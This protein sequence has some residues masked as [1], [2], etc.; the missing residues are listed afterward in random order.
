MN[1]SKILQT[2]MYLPKNIVSNADLEKMIETSDDWIESRTG[3]K[4]RHI[5]SANENS[6]TMAIAAAKS[7]LA[8]H[9]PSSID[10]LIVA[11][12]TP[13]KLMPSTACAV[14]NEL[15]L[16]KA[17]CFDLNAACSGF[18]YAITCADQYIKSGMCKKVLVIGSDA[19]TKIIDWED[20][21]T[22]VLFGDGAGAVLLGASETPGIL[23]SYLGSDGES[24]GILS[25]TGS[26]VQAAMPSYIEMKGKDVFKRAVKA[27]EMV[28]GEVLSKAKLTAKDIDWLVPHQANKRIIT[29]TANAL[30]MPLDKIIMTVD[31]HANTSAASIP[32][33]LH[34]GIS[35]GKIK[36]GD[37]MLLESFGA[38][39]T[40]GAS[41]IQY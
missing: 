34:A 5:V 32:L 40:W 38:G 21:S 15:G 28:V 23:A 10:L 19:M 13:N 7:I 27:L 37:V 22:C 30:D 39:F 26:I 18:V 14:Q 41:L 6:T 12:C 17:F 16:D 8:D 1:Y 36:Q 9:D 4:Q 11:T 33:A 25:T 31:K 29:A 3:I 24:D 2:G 35:S 20:R